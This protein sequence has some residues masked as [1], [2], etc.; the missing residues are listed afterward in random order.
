[1]LNVLSDKAQRLGTGRWK[2]LHILRAMIPIMHSVKTK[3][4]LPK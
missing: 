4:Y 3:K 2:K 1:M